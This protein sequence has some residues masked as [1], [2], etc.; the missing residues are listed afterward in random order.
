MNGLFGEMELPQL[1]QIRPAVQLSG[2]SNVTA[3]DESAAQLI[4]VVKPQ[5]TN[6]S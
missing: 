5:L 2:T 4:L 3:V 1:T 6:Y